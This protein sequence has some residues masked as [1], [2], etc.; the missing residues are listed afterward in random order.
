MIKRPPDF[1]VTKV[2]GSTYLERWYLIPKNR[3][4]NIYLHHFMQ[5]DEDRALHDHPWWSLGILLKGKYKEHLPEGKTRM[6]FVGQPTIRP[7]NF[8]H[9]IELTDGPVWTLFITGPARS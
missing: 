1:I 4:F 5:S 7:A 3:F 8:L 6:K 9:R 2:D